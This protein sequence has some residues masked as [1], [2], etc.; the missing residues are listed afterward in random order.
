[1]N[2][3]IVETVWMGRE[4]YGVFDTALLTAFSILPTLQARQLAAITPKQHAVTLINER[5]QQI[6]FDCGY[7]VVLINF[8]TPTAPR[9][10]AIADAFRSRHVPVVLSGIHASAVP[11]EAKEHADAVLLGR[12]EPAWP[13]VLEDLK[14]RSLKPF[15]PPVPYPAEGS[16]PDSK[17]ELPG[18]VV[19]GAVEASRGCPYRCEFC[20]ESH[21][22]ADQPFVQ[23]PA[24][25]VVEEVRRLPQRI[26]M[27]YDGTL[28]ADPGYAKAL[29]FKLRGV[30]KRFFVN[31][32]V[33]VLARD[34][35]LVRLSRE[36]G[37]LGWFIGFESVC[38]A[39]LASYRKRTNRLAEYRA[40]VESIHRYGM[41]VFGSF[42]FGADAEST[43]VFEETRRVIE[44]LG[45]DVVDF[46]VLTPLPGTPLF[47]RLEK[48]GRI[49]TR[50]WSRYTLNQVVFV[51]KQ[52]TAEQLLRGTQGLFAWFYSP[53]N[54]VRR[55]ARS[56]R[57]GLLPFWVVAGRNLVAT[58][59]ARRLLQKD[60]VLEAEDAERQ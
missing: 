53:K 24:E 20:P 7:D 11:Q 1:M 33:D 36:A 17:V 52:M 60:A 3:L 21:L 31:G 44:E 32:N 25:E 14:K 59:G 42:M 26:V 4:R 34:P 29:F 47:T 46:C 50:D 35:E 56:L 6:D 39:S 2:I 45:L 37:C 15:Y 48:E 54:T 27:F 9:A 16:L 8:T 23:R 49:L 5:Y 12:G 30:G 19:M 40:A 51:P 57:L 18:F 13:G 41:V 28:T 43:S 58:M 38:E 55:L 22:S 10:Y